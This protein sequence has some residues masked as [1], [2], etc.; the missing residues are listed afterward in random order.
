[1]YA[2]KQKEE[3]HRNQSIT[4]LMQSIEDVAKPETLP[5]ALLGCDEAQL[6]WSNPTERGLQVVVRRL[7]R[8]IVHEQLPHSQVAH[9]AVC[10]RVG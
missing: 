1:M 7:E 3:S 8:Q 10:V 4:H 2:C 6:D 9:G 5:L